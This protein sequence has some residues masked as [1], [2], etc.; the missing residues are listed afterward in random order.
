MV[1]TIY[2]N[3]DF[4]W[5]I[6]LG[7]FSDPEGDSLSY[8]FPGIPS[9]FTVTNVSGTNYKISST[10]PTSTANINFQFQASD[11][12]SKPTTIPVTIKVGSCD[13]KCSKCY[14]PNDNECY[15]CKGTFVLE[16]NTCVNGCPA[17]KFS[18]NGVCE[19]CHDF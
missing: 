14:G 2:P 16:G 12:I 18:N 9:G 15:T 8:S 3:D 4:T 5:N 7:F 10:F 6:N 11:G 13:T 17:G 1:H 19:P